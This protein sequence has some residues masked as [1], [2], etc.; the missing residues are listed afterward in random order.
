MSTW[1]TTVLVLVVWVV[2]ALG[3]GMVLGRVVRQR[4]AR[5]DVEQSQSIM[6][7]ANAQPSAGRLTAEP[8]RSPLSD[9]QRRQ[10]SLRQ[11]LQRLLAEMERTELDG[12][13]GEMADLCRIWSARAHCST[14]EQEL[15]QAIEQ[16]RRNGRAW[17]TI[18]AVL[19]LPHPTPLSSD[20]R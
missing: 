15:N 18:K 14:A 10:Q 16:A 1:S 6:S 13:A 3:A 9:A 19:E 20:S 5:R 12:S 8:S 2:V 17:S 7:D 4:D 11:E